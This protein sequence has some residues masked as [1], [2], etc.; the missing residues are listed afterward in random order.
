M[1]KTTKKRPQVKYIL[2]CAVPFVAP[3]EFTSVPAARTY[4]KECDIRHDAR[5]VLVRVTE[6]VVR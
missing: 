4:M 6:E 3:V 2:R 5:F 1:K